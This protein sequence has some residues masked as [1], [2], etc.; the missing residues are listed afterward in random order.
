MFRKTF[1]YTMLPFNCMDWDSSDTPILSHFQNKHKHFAFLD[2]WE[3]KK[4]WSQTKIKCWTPGWEQ[5]MNLSQIR[6]TIIVMIKLINFCSPIIHTN[7][8]YTNHKFY[9]SKLLLVSNGNI[10]FFVLFVYYLCC[11]ISNVLYYFV[12]QFITLLNIRL[13]FFFFLYR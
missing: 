9:K 11:T 1:I 12:L 5:E 4:L 6:K 8:K 13:S 3:L 2:K 7:T 10:T